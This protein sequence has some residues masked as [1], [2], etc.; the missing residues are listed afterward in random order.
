MLKDFNQFSHK[1]KLLV[2]VLCLCFRPWR[3]LRKPLIS[4]ERLPFFDL[5]G[6]IVYLFLKN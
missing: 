2:I 3:I 6:K 5:P 1:N 4:A